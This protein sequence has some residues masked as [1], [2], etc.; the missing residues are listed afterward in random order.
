MHEKSSLDSSYQEEKQVVCAFY[1][2]PKKT[3]KQQLQITTFSAVVN[4]WL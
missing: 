3:K 2:K 4:V 1:I